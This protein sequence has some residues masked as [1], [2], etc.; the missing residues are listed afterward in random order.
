MKNK[1]RYV[2][3]WKRIIDLTGPDGNAYY[4]LGLAQVFANQLG[5]DGDEICRK[6]TSSDS[7]FNLVTVFKEEFGNYVELVGEVRPD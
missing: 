3:T 5:K 6:M 2:R 4:L 1:K 7:Y